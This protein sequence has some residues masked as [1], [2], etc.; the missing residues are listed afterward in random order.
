MGY[1]SEFFVCLLAIIWGL[2]GFSSAVGVGCCETRTKDKKRNGEN[3]KDDET[4][5]YTTAFILA[6]VVSR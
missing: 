5:W 2:G 1:F 4:G 3:N 6:F